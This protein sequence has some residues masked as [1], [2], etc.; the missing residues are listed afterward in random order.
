MVH[1]N[2]AFSENEDVRAKENQATFKELSDRYKIQYGVVFGEAYDAD[3]DVVITRGAPYYGR[4]RYIVLKAPDDIS[5]DELALICDRG[6][7]CFG[8]SGNRNEIVIFTD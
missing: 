7:L 1:V 2:W 5:V 8:Y 3:S 4:V 6:N